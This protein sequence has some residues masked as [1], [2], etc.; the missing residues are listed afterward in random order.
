MNR[1]ASSAPLLALS[2]LG[3]ASAN[4]EAETVDMRASPLAVTMNFE[5]SSRYVWRGIV[6]N[7]EFVAQPN[8]ALAFH[9]FSAGVW[10]SFDLTNYSQE[11]GGADRKGEF[12]EV[13]ISLGYSHG[14]KKLSLSVGV[15]RYQYPGSEV[16]STDDLNVG[17]VAN[18]P[19]AVSFGAWHALEDGGLYLVTGASHVFTL[20]ARATLKLGAELGW[21]DATCAD[22]NYGVN[23]SGLTHVGL[24]LDVPLV[25]ND[26]F[27]VRPFV[28]GSSILDS[29]FRDAAGSPDA[30]A[31][32]VG[33]DV[34]F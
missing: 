3:L 24:A 20:H 6:L 26:R 27:S 14:F 4:A 7:D 5:L 11:H 12:S 29:S 18:L 13:D 23:S 22:I 25:V 19:V 2:L 16:S 33:L 28:R 21:A 10:G 17:L 32:G 34:V 8:V 30:L 9:G 31:V 15:V 1:R